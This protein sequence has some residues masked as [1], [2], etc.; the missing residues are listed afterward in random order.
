MTP[1]G[2]SYKILIQ[3]CTKQN[4]TEEKHLMS[5]IICS[6][7]C[8]WYILSYQDIQCFIL[9]VLFVFVCFCNICC[10][11]VVMAFC[12]TLMYFHLLLYLFRTSNCI[13]EC[14]WFLN[15]LRTDSLYQNNR[16][17]SVK[18]YE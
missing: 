14:A 16:A 6:P 2:C 3:Q 4:P 13:C 7:E 1:L 12:S 5:L 15:W 11:A 8:T 17:T 10:C 18:F 9:H